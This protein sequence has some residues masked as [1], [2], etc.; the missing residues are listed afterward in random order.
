[1]RI[2]EKD[3]SAIAPSV[4]RRSFRLGLCVSHASIRE[5]ML[6]GRALLHAPVRLTGSDRVG[7]NRDRAVRSDRGWRHN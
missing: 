6:G 1:M 3:L 7:W 2:A 4:A 5:S